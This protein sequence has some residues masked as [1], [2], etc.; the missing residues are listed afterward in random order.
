MNRNRQQFVSQIVDI[1]LRFTVSSG[2]PTLIAGSHPGVASISYTAT[3]KYTITLRKGYQFLL[4]VRNTIFKD[5]G[6][7]NGF[8]VMDTGT[9][10]STGV[11]VL[12]FEDDGSAAALPDGTHS[13]CLEVCPQSKLSR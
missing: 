5:T 10:I 2:T 8:C 11:V 3:G 13:I 9:S 12:L 1:W 6:A 7:V 4:G